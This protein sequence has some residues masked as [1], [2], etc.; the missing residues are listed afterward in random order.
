MSKPSA[1]ERREMPDAMAELRATADGKASAEVVHLRTC[2]E[3]LQE[4][5]RIEGIEPHG[6]LGV[7]SRALASALGGLAIVLEMLAERVEHKAEAVEQA[8]LAEVARVKAAVDEARGLTNRLKV[9]IED[10]KERRKEENLALA[11][12]LGEGIKDTLKTALLIRERRW[13]RR[14]NWTA[15]V[16]TAT[17]LVGCFIAGVGWSDYSRPG[18]AV[19]EVV[20]RCVARKVLDAVTHQ[21][22]CPVKSVLGEP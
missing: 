9:E 17:V 7:W 2:C 13:N 18:G 3:Q 22:Y 15:A 20:D 11:R 4:A 12:E 19:Q 8:M 5:L 1:P 16:L 10:N 21:Y 14:Q 6:P